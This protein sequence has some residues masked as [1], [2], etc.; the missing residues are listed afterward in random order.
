MLRAARFVNSGVGGRMNGEDLF[1]VV[2]RR[3]LGFFFISLVVS[4][5]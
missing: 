1:E 3:R 2:R 5:I 4:S